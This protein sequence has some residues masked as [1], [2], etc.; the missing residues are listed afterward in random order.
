MGGM[1]GG[2]QSQTTNESKQIKLPAW[3]EAAG[4]NNYQRA[5]GIADRPYQ[6]YGGQTVAGLSPEYFAAQGMLGNL[7]DYMGNYGNA[8]NA[9]QG[10]IDYNPTAIDPSSYTAAQFAGTDLAPY[11]NP[12]IQNVENRAVDTMTRTGQTALRD[13]ASDATKKGAFGGSRAALQGAVQGAET[14]RGIGDLSANLRKQGFDA[15]TGLAKG[16]IE[17]RNQ[18]FQKVGDWRQQAQIESERNKLADKGLD[19]QAAQGLTSTADAA[20]KAWL[21]NIMAQLG[22]GQIGQ[23]QNQRVLDDAKAKWERKQNY[24]I[25]MLNL[26]SAQLGLTPYGHTETGTSTTKSSG[27]GGMGGMLNMLPGIM[28]LAGGLSDREPKTNIEK[29]GVDPLTKLEMYAYRLQIRCQGI[30][31]DRQRPADEARR[32]DGPGCRKE[33]PRIGA[34]GGRQAHHRPDG[35]AG[36]R[37]PTRSTSSRNE[38]AAGRTSRTTSTGRVSPRPATTRSSMARG[39]AGRR[40]PGIDISQY[41][42]AMMRP[43]GG[44]GA[45]ARAGLQ[46]GRLPAMGSDQ[47]SRRPGEELQPRSAFGD[48][49]QPVSGQRWGRER[50]ASLPHAACCEH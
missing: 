31:K 39:G 36:L 35:G 9:Y 46:D 14:A 37:W 1:M 6:E 22:I 28:Q 50:S 27:G 20:Q 15:A 47:A 4:Q 45:V 40:R 16:D 10:V 8:S 24:P 23:E 29:I 49:R 19:V 18:Q 38:R 21:N 3:V 34:Q 25:E 43:Q 17:A 33:V 42:R 32:P 5:Q 26:L 41:P 13:L 11:L 48:P 7:D 12:Y 44:A 30:E 2:G